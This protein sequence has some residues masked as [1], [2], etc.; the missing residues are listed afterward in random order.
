MTKQPKKMLVVGTGPIGCELGQGFAR[1]GTEVTMTHRGSKI[2]ANDDE[3][4]TKF[5]Y[6]QMLEDGI[7]FLHKTNITQIS[8]LDE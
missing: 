2:L 4:G 6:D 1:L 7:K 8:V 5:V 3:E